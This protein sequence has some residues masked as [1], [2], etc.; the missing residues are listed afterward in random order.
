MSV[1]ATNPHTTLT[2]VAA[3]DAGRAPL[4][5][6]YTYSETNDGTDPI[7]DVAIT[8][9]GCAPLTPTGGDANANAVLDPGETWTYTCNRTFT[10]PGTFTNKVTGTGT[11]TVDRLQAPLETA[12]GSVTVQPPLPPPTVQSQ[13]PAQRRREGGLPLTGLEVAGLVVVG[14]ALLGAG[15]LLVGTARRRRQRRV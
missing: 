5:V 15:A 7:A 14:L 11:S 4:N 10:E 2:V 13:P 9:D 12:Q 1:T 3:P 6:T 8:D